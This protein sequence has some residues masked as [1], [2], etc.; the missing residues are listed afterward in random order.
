MQQEL[1]FF[2]E[3]G[4]GEK[5]V[6][7]SFTSSLSPSYSPVH[8]FPFLSTISKPFSM[9]V[10]APILKQISKCMFECVDARRT[11]KKDIRR[12]LC[13]FSGSF[14]FL[15]EC[16]RR[17]AEAN[18]VMSSASHN[19]ELQRLLRLLHAL[20]LI[21]SSFSHSLDAINELCK[22]SENASRSL[23]HMDFN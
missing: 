6:W 11:R 8:F 5:R 7:I 22:R 17:C 18:V 1:Q 10:A 12:I 4:E 9:L 21:S 23:P 19:C 15:P 3:R 16:I 2:N 14:F 13:T 20:P